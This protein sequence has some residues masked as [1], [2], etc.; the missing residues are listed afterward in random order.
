MYSLLFG[1]CLAIPNHAPP[2]V[3]TAWPRLLQQ[4][5]RPFY[6]SKQAEAALKMR[7]TNASDQ[8]F[9]T[10]AWQCENKTNTHFNKRVFAV[11]SSRTVQ[12]LQLFRFT[13][14]SLCIF[15]W[16][17]STLCLFAYFPADLP[18]LHFICLSWSFRWIYGYVAVKRKAS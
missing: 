14:C 11:E 2:S 10:F 4:L 9:A 7:R 17:C 6:G 12:Q 13:A 1:I 3:T 5:Q 18:S 8:K 15:G 16:L